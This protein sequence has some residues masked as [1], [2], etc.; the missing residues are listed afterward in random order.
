MSPGVAE[1]PAEPA[2]PEPLRAVAAH[3]SA[4]HRLG[5]AP[6]PIDPPLGVVVVSTPTFS[7]TVYPLLTSPVTVGIWVAP[8]S[9]PNT[10]S[11]VRLTLARVDLA[12][13]LPPVA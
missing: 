13:S 6:P 10:L 2:T 12:A 4:I 8:P 11:L 9:S 7:A 3:R 5:G 1:T